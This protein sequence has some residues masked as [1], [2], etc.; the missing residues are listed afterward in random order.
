[1]GHRS[2]INIWEDNWIPTNQNLKP[3]WSKSLDGSHLVNDL[4]IPGRRPWNEHLIRSTFVQPN[5]E[6]IL[7]IPLGNIEEDVMAWAYE[8]FDI[9]TVRYAYHFISEDVDRQSQSRN[10]S[11]ISSNGHKQPMWRKDWKLRTPSK[12]RVFWWRLLH[13]SLPTRGNLFMKHIGHGKNLSILW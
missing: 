12:V 5:A 4:L 8:K 2:S 9:Y 3:I 1:M 13:N 10:T 11:G 6:A 7:H